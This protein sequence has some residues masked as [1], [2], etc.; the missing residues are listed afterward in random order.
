MRLGT[1]ATLILFC[2]SLAAAQTSEVAKTGSMEPGIQIDDLLIVDQN[3]Y[4][5]KP[6]SRFDIV[7]FRP[8][9]QGL[10]VGSAPDKAVARVIAMG[11]ET[12]TIK[13]NNVFINGK[14][15]QEPYS[16]RPCDGEDGPLPCANFG[17]LKVPENEYFLLADNRGQSQDSRLWEPPTISRN[18][19]IGKVIKVVSN[20]KPSD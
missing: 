2:I 6:V 18:Q 13:K 1:V 4:S 16:T 8:A 17:P 12:I 3:Y 5:S 10:Y 20:K 7:V 19:I 11:G 9:R 15:L 14:A